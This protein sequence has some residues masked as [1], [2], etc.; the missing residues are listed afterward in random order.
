MLK[1]VEDDAG[2]QI[3]TPVVLE[4]SL[5]WSSILPQIVGEREG[6]KFTLGVN[7]GGASSFLRFENILR[8]FVHTP[9]TANAGKEGTYSVAIK[10]T[11]TDGITSHFDLR[12][13]YICPVIKP[14]V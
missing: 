11:D 14:F 9:E 8:K 13:N 4:C 12:I 7:L 10:I 2:V 3:F 1:F 6:K 5:E